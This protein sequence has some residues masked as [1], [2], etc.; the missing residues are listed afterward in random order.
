MTYEKGLIFK[1]S[2]F[3]FL[4]ITKIN[5]SGLEYVGR[6]SE[7]TIGTTVTVLSQI[8][9]PTQQCF[10]EIKV[11]CCLCSQYRYK[12]TYKSKLYI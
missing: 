10:H 11:L 3:K 6:M 1:N 7:R 9:H 4:H 5:Y 12:K 2:T 8:N